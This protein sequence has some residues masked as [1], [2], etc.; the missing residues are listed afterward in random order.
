MNGTM[1]I[2][3]SEVCVDLGVSVRAAWRIQSAYQA[4]LV[5]FFRFGR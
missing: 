3:E 1:L 2:S 4:Q 5:R